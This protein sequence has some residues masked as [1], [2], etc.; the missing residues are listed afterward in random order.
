MQIEETRDGSVVVLSVVGRLDHAGAGVLDARADA[1]MAEGERRL[2]FDFHG[3][4][5]VASTGIRAIIRPY[6]ALAPLGGRL[7]IANLSPTIRHVFHIAGI[8]RAVPVHDSVADAVA[9]LQE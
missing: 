2:V 5:F 4:D 1:L 8:D 9:S 7:A 3:V 6:Q